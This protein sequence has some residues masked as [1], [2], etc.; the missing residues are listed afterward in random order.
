MDRVALVGKLFVAYQSGDFAN[1]A[2]LVSPQVRLEP[3]GTDLQPGPVYEGAAGVA[4]WAREL[5]S[6]QDEFQPSVETMEQVGERVL[7]IGGI[8]VAAPSGLVG[9]T[10]VAWLCEFDEHGRLLRLRTYL[11]VEEARADAKAR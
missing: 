10:P 4:E 5:A 6:S 8:Q 7:A 1:F 11:D 2:E 9:P 3:V